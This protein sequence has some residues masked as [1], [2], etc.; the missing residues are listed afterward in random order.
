MLN[1][2]LPQAA[3]VAGIN[4]GPSGTW[5]SLAFFS[6]TTAEADST[7]WCESHSVSGILH[8]YV[9]AYT[10]QDYVR[11]KPRHA[12]GQDKHKYAYTQSTA[13]FTRYTSMHK[14][15]ED[16]KYSVSMI[17]KSLFFSHSYSWTNWT[18]CQLALSCT[19]VTHYS[20]GTEKDNH[21][22]LSRYL[23]SLSD[24]SFQHSDQIFTPALLHWS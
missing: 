1:I 14:A 20:L 18:H 23:D 21:H 19:L 13:A 9:C 3:E 8:L 2:E 12:Q 17:I 22:Y 4:D 10:D 16:Y 7:Q 24:R 6:M 5:G 11:S 15:V